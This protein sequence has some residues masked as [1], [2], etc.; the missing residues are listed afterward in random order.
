V[1]AKLGASVAAVGLFLYA[2]H[3]HIHVPKMPDLLSAA[4][5]AAHV[6]GGTLNCAGL[7]RL[8][9]SAGGS[10]GAAFTAAEIAMAE[11]GGQQYA[12]DN[13]G[14]GTVDRGYFQINSIWGS[15]STYDPAGNARAAVRISR[16]GSDWTP[17]VTWNSG[18]YQG[19]C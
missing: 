7:E 14:N 3:G 2:T 9:E 6:Q 12:T 18:A 5:T 19:K 13:D 15:E 10:P 8:W 1:N 11:S 17:W 16:D 4:T